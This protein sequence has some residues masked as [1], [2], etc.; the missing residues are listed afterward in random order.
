[1]RRYENRV[2]INWKFSTLLL[3]S[4]ETLFGVERL[5]IGSENCDYSLKKWELWQVLTREPGC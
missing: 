1:M 4:K 2:D 3:C 5:S